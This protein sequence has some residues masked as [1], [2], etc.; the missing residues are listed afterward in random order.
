LTELAQVSAE[1]GL[2][3]RCLQRIEKAQRVV[4]DMV[5]TIACLWLTVRA[6]VEALALAPAVEHAV[7]DAVMPAISLA[8]AAQK[9][10][11]AEQRHTLRERAEA[12]RLPLCARDGPWGGLRQAE[13]PLIEQSAASCAQVL[14]RSSACGEGRNGQLALRPHRLHR[15]SDRKLAALTTV[16]NAWVTRRDETTAAERFFGAKPKDLFTW[17]LTRGE[18]PGRPAQKRSQPQTDVS[19]FQVLV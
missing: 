2:P 5:A 16:H 12:L 1:A 9:T 15:I 17:V 4:S 6:K 13:R 14:Q 19:R 10:T 7:Y 8:L 18:L 3:E 11:R